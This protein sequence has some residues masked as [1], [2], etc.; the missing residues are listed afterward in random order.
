GSV[1]L[2]LRRIRRL[3]AGDD[4]GSGDGQRAS[5]LAAAAVSRRVALSSADSP[6]RPVA[7]RLPPRL[8]DASTGEQPYGRAQAAR[9]QGA[10][11][12]VDV[13]VR[14]L[15]GPLVA[16]SGDAGRSGRS[17]PGRTG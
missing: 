10:V 7:R 6:R 16:A 13:A 11:G 12:S 15:A 8:P 3:A 2:D 9:A 5:L 14:A 17:L 1:A 4:A